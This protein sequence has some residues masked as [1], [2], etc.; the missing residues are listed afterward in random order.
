MMSIIFKILLVFT[1][2]FPSNTDRLGLSTIEVLVVD[3]TV[4]SLINSI[5]F[6]IDL[7]LNNM[8]LFEP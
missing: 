3:N 4:I 5:E 2:R 6:I 8:H 1:Y 7:S